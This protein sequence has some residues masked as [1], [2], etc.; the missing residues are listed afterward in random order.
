MTAYTFS[1]LIDFTRT[2]SATYVNAS[3]VVTVTPASTNLLL[4]TQA[5]AT[6]PWENL[7]SGTA[8]APTATNNAGI[9]PDGTGTAT[10]LQFSLG[11]G[12]ATTDIAR[13]RQPVTLSALTY[14]L[15]VWIKS[16]DGSSSYNMH[17]QDAGGATRL[18]TVTGAWTR[19]D[20]SSLAPG[21]ALNVSIGLRGGQTPANSNTADVLV[22]GAQLELGSTASAYVKNV[23][24]FFP[25]RFDYN[26]TTL[27]PRGFLIEEQRTNVALQSNDFTVGA[28]WQ[29]TV[30]GTST[31]TNGSTALGFTQGVITATSTN[32]GV[33]QQIGS[34]LS[35]QVYTLSFYIQ[36]TATAITLLFENSTATFGAPH[37]VVINPSNGTA[38]ALTGFTSVSITPYGSGYVYSLTTAPAGGLLL[39]NAEWRIP[40]NGEVINLGRPQFEAGSFPTSYIPTVA[41]TVTRAADTA[42]IAAPMFAPW[43]SQTEGTFIAEASTITATSN[44]ILDAS[45]GVGSRVVDLLVVTSAGANIQF[46]N[47]TTVFTTLNALTLGTPFKTAAA[48]KTADYAVVLNGGAPAT[49]NAALVNTANALQIGRI[50]T[51]TSHL[52]GHIRS[53][54]YYPLRLT[55]AQLQGLTT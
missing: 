55:N 34:L 32:G 49:N 43:Y 51:G 31:R 14:D 9:A 28:I 15:S 48:Y 22:W 40:N 8:L 42:V 36:S 18:I 35:G 47:G 37:V 10:R 19:Y 13:R 33:R 17:L 7:N 6:A 54:N 4:Y 38:G 46:Y 53:I 52:N 11:G 25:P 26:P 41:S 44:R 2:T 20:V 50:S 24:G 23:G 5:L 12:T 21:G 29:A 30:S 27:A 16:T 3:G 1:Q 39:V 45:A